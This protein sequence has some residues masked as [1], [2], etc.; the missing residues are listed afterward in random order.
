MASGTLPVMYVNT[1]NATPIVDKE[2]KIPATLYV[3]VPDDYDREALGS[4]ASPVELT[5][6]GRGNASWLGPK[7][8]YKIKFESKTAVLGMPKHKHFALIPFAGG[9]A[10]WLAANAGMELGR[11]AGMS[12]APR[13][14]PCELVLNGRYD[15]LYFMVESMKIDK[16]RL[17]IFEQEDLC[18]DTELIKGGWLVEIDNYEDP[19]Q[20]II[21]ETAGKRLRVTYKTPEELSDLQ[22]E[23]LIEQFT[24]MNEAI[25]SGD[26]TGEAYCEY[27]DVN[28]IARYFIVREI[29][30]D[31]DGYN[32]S[33]YL[34]K[35]LG[36][37][38][39]WNFGPLW[40]LAFGGTKKDWIMN[41]HPAYSAI[42][43]IE[44]ITATSA[45][46]SALREDWNALMTKIDAIYPYI[47]ALAE[48]CAAADE[49]DF[50]R[51]PD[52]GSAGAEGKARYLKNGIKANVEWIEQN[53]PALAGVA[54]YPVLPSGPARWFNLQGT[55]VNSENA[56]GGIYIVVDEHGARKVVRNF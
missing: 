30:H 6:K 16:N 45:F 33:F 9:Y 3:T 14:E 48:R 13:M 11:L 21:Q 1:E 25:Y 56:V 37:D 49:A 34:H 36:D 4:E 42:H 7:K 54:T 19:C 12:W 15:G 47:D 17:N 28:S 35:D 50:K 40:D 53:I 43:W 27:I 41:D 24:L 55:E 29:L 31:T 5:I 22:Q 10:G 23:H 20:I 52:L 18:T 32:G 51:W 8:P 44:P 39:K 2:T 38:A 26:A 46:N